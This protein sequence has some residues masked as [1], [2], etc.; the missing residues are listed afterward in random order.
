MSQVAPAPAALVRPRGVPTLWAG[1]AVAFLLVSLVI[2]IAVGPVD[3]G[4]LDVLRSVGARLGVGVS[5]LDAIDESI[6]WDIRIPRV[7]LAAL[8]GMTLALS[9]AT[10]QGVFRN[11]LADPYLLGV[12]AGT[13][14][15][16]VA[17]LACGLSAGC[18]IPLGMAFVGDTV[19]F[20][21]SIFCAYG[22]GTIRCVFFCPT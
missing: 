7:V 14:E 12:A 16:K 6:L 9:G 2:G 8:V 21:F 3:L 15:K 18:I 1:A 11:A 13:V 10:Y 22:I 19:P 20:A 5:P 4:V 17:R